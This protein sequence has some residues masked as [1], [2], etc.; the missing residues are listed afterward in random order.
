MLWTAFSEF[1][2]KSGVG[3]GQEH[4]LIQRWEDIV[5]VFQSPELVN[6][7]IE[8]EPSILRW[9]RRTARNALH[10][11][12]IY[13]GEEVPDQTVRALWFLIFLSGVW[14]QG[15][16][17]FERNVKVNMVSTIGIYSSSIPSIHYKQSKCRMW[18]CHSEAQRPGGE[19]SR[20]RMSLPVDQEC[21][22]HARVPSGVDQCPW[23]PS[24]QFSL[25]QV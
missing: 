18:R 14:M 6:Q 23:L 4:I 2:P 22:E 8:D 21:Q 15:D 13:L 16:G 7:L 1:S 3:H 19:R 24:W 25:W 12:E 9:P 20:L 10:Y 17:V 5:D 11:L